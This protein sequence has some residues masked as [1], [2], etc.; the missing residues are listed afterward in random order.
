M[1]LGSTCCRIETGGGLQV[2]SIVQ[3]LQG[4]PQLTSTD[5][6][7]WLGLEP[8]TPEWTPHCSWARPPCSP[9]PCTPQ[10][11]SSS[12]NVPAGTQQRQPG[13]VASAVP[14]HAAHADPTSQQSGGREEGRTPT[15]AA[16]GNDCTTDYPGGRDEPASSIDKQPA[17]IQK[18]LMVCTH[19]LRKHHPSYCL[20]GLAYSAYLLT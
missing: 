8:W 6:L 15:P 11:S 17:D 4:L 2:A 20:H 19:V 12:T 13:D 9:L 5:P 16:C 14:V 7:C 18:V 10:A 1:S 3:Q